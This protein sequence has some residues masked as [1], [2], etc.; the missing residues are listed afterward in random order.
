VSTREELIESCIPMVYHFASRM[1]AGN[2]YLD[3]TDIVSE[4]YVGLVQA[5]NSYD[6]T[7]G[8][9]FS[10]F[11]AQ[12]IRGAMI[13]AVRSAAPLSRKT[14]ATVRQYE[15]AV[16]QVTAETRRSAEDE[17]VAARLNIGVKDVKKM[18]SWNSFRLLSLDDHH[19][20]S[21]SFDIAD[22]FSLEDD[23]I[24]SVSGDSLRSYIDRLLPR[25]R[26][27]IDRIYF[28]GY[29]QRTVAQSYNISESRLSQVRRRAL[30]SLRSMIETDGELAAA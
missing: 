30:E 24:A 14:A 22:D 5:A 25:D 21:Q 11:A 1:N 20:D 12:R 2:T 8:A 3:Y 10:S 4:G 17:E 16:D 26:Q 18:K 7:M 13:D 23:V 28:Q 6:E 15:D 9:S 29:S 27:I 19:P